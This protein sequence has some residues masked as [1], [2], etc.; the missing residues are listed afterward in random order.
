[1]SKSS[2]ERGGSPVLLITPANYDERIWGRLATE[3]QRRAPLEVV[4]WPEASAPHSAA[5]ADPIRPLE[6]AVQDRC[7]DDLGAV[8]AVGPDA[9]AAVHL[10]GRGSTRSIVLIDPN[11]GRSLPEVPIP[12]L[13]ERLERHLQSLPERIKE[14]IARRDPVA[15]AAGVAAES[16]KYL[17]DLDAQALRE[18]LTSAAPTLL[19]GHERVY[20]GPW[21]P[22]RLGGLNVPVLVISSAPADDDE[23]L[24][25]RVARALVQRCQRGSLARVRAETE[26]PWL[27]QTGA[28]AG[29]IL[30]FID[31]WLNDPDG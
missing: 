27:E 7:A 8:V 31:S 23:E 24:P 10:G 17:S 2:P 19:A 15:F 5:H 9:A 11:P 28:V 6:Q 25:L 21:W 20:D 14:A 1:M 3:L 29:A 4:I 18:V 12:D 13:E 26:Y 16:A 30:E 22:D